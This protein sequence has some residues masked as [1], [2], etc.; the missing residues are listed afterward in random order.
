MYIHIYVYNKGLL[1]EENQILLITIF[2]RIHTR[3]KKG[4]ERIKEEI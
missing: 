3:S 4:K 1:E 2:F